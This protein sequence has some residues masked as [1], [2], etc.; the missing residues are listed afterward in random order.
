MATR[1]DFHISFSEYQAH[2]IDVNM[3]IQGFSDR[4]YLDITMPV[5]TPGSYLI[6][7]CRAIFGSG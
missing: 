2:Y 6:Q 7:K 3:H 1:I 4:E 5:W